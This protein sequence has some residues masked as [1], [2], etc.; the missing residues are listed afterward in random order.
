M[1]RQRK[2]VAAA[3]ETEVRFRL[4]RVGSFLARCRKIGV[5][6]TAPVVQNDRYFHE[7]GTED[8]QRVPGSFVVR[9]REQRGKLSLMTM[10]V[11]TAKSGQW[12]EYE[13][14]VADPAAVLLML[15]ILGLRQTLQILKSRRKGIVGKVEVCLDKIEGLG[16]FVELEYLGSGGSTAE[17]ELRKAASLLGLDGAVERRGYVELARA[18]QSRT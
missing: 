15:P 10:K 18:A 3:Y 5:D 4:E 12:C 16:S 2:A 13:T 17:R 8:N 1:K 14:Q 9:V 6:L 7:P 11:T